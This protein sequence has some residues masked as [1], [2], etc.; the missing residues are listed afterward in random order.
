[1]SAIQQALLMYGAKKGIIQ[2]NLVFHLDPADPASYS[3]SGTNW[4]DLT[5]NAFDATLVN[6]PTFDATDGGGSFDFNGVN[7]KATQPVSLTDE[8][9]GPLTFTTS[10]WIKPATSPPFQEAIWGVF[11]GGASRQSRM[12]CRIYFNGIIRLGY[13]AEDLDTPTGNIT[14]GSWQYI[15][16]QYDSATDTSKVFVNGVEKA[17]GS[18]GGLLPSTDRSVGFAQFNNSEWYK[19]KLGSQDSYSVALTATQITENFDALKSRY[20]Y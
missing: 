18:Q 15:T 16:I 20:G 19:G 17:S 14:F 7:Q 12:L 3:G 8:F 9:V 11:Q 10:F 4:A 2:N 1:M 5:A 13:F 6:S